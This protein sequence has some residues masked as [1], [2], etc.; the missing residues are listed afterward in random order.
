M[1]G[2]MVRRAAYLWM[3]LLR[4]AALRSLPLHQLH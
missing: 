3:L 4:L 1:I 2:C